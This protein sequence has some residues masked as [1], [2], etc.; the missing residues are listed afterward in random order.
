MPRTP[1]PR[2]RTRRPTSIEEAPTGVITEGCYRQVEFAGILTGAAHPGPAGQLIDFMLSQGLSGDNPPDLVRVPGQHRGSPAPRIRRAHRDTDRSGP[3]GSCRHRGQPPI[4]AG[5]VGGHLPMNRRGISLAFAIPALFL[6]YFFLYPLA[7]ILWLSL[8]G[9]GWAE[10]F[11]RPRFI[12]AAWFTLWQAS[13]STVLTVAAAMPLTW[14]LSRFN[15]PGKGPRQGLRHHSLCASHSGGRCGFPLRFRRRARGAHCSPRVLQ[16]RRGRAHRR[17]C[18][19][20]D[21]PDGRGSCRGARCRPDPTV[22]NG[23]FPV[24]PSGA[25][26]GGCHRV[27]FLLHLLRD[28]PGARSGTTPH[29]RG[30]DLSAGRQL[31]R[32]SRRRRAFPDPTRHRDGHAGRIGQGPKER[33]CPDPC[34]GSPASRSEAGRGGEDRAGD[35]FRFDRHCCR[36]RWS[37]WS[38]PHSAAAGSDG[39]RSWPTLPR[40]WSHCLRS[41]TPWAL[42]WWPP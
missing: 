33:V 38:E 4:V 21:R 15:F 36:S 20:S 5:T 11:T 34:L 8:G 2:R 24:D 42:R 16:H 10:A 29:S 1:S 25:G 12:E 30:R 26:I 7:R 19:E 40:R 27:S 31:S 17:R 14:V 39:G 6:S 22:P 37:G 18:L 32:P 9:D 35:S 23:G 3:D 41:A 13:L 28:S